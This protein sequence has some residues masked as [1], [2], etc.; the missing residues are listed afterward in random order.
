MKEGWLSTFGMGRGLRRRR[1]RRGYS[2]EIFR[3]VRGIRVVRVPVFVCVVR[4]M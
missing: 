3:V 4:D 2:Q 1:G